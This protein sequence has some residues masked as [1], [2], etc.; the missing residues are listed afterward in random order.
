MRAALAVLCCL[1]C[2]WSHHPAVYGLAT[3]DTLLFACDATQTYTAS[4]GGAWDG[5]VHEGDPV[6]GRA[7][8]GARMYGLMAINIGVAVAVT[9]LPIPDW[10]KASALGMIGANVTRGVLRNSRYA[11]GCGLG[12]QTAEAAIARH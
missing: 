12:T 5:G 2:S 10:A 3:V 11:T 7:P 8:S 4:N 9:A 1:G 6:Q